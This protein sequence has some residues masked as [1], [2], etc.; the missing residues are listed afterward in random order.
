VEDP[1]TVRE[2]VD[3]VNGQI[4]ADE[5]D[6]AYVTTNTEPFYLPVNKHK[7]K[8]AALAAAADL[9]SEVEA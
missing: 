4:Q 1:E 8:L 9:E 7:E 5:F 2:R 3:W 6:T